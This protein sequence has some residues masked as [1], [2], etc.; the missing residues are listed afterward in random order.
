MTSPQRSLSLPHRVAGVAAVGCARLLACR[1]PHRRQRV[2]LAL[3]RGAAP[4][5][6]ER[7][8]FARRVV[9]TV[10]Q[11][12]SGEH[13]VQRSFATVLLCRLRGTWPT[14]CDGVRTAPF[15]AHAWV[16]ADG[17]PIGEPH[18]AGDYRPVLTV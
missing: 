13:C 17:R 14:W 1:R 15:T 16:E 3:R 4:A 7:T 9:T 2:L 12:C 6:P 8:A 11:R 5:T 10:S 18:A